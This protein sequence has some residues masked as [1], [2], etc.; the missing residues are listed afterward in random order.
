L[1]VSNVFKEFT[2][3][4]IRFQSL[5]EFETELIKDPE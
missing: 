5:L 3:K 2:L 1:E 4:D